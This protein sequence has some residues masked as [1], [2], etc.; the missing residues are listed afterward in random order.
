MA[1]LGLNASAN[2]IQQALALSEFPRE[3]LDLF[4]GV[5]MVNRTAR[6]LIRMR[7]EQGM[8]QIVARAIAIDRAGKSS[9]KSWRSSAA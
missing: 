2:R 4:K 5:G 1:K 3:V 7:N 6:E 8:E 9:R